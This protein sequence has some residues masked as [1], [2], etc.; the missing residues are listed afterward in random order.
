MLDVCRCTCVSSTKLSAAVNEPNN[1]YK[2]EVSVNVSVLCALCQTDDELAVTLERC[3]K[4][5][6]KS[7]EAHSKAAQERASIKADLDSVKADLAKIRCS[8]F[9]F[10]SQ[11]PSLLLDQLCM[12]S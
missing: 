10:V 1:P 9:A 4:V 3:A 2:Y 12:N 5:E 6:G 8:C 11:V 7:E